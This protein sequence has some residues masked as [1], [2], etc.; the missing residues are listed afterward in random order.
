MKFCLYPIFEKTTGQ[1]FKL[2]DIQNNV[3]AFVWIFFWFCAELSFYKY[4][5][6][7]IRKLTIKM[8]WSPTKN[9]YVPRNRMEGP[10]K[11]K[12]LNRISRRKK[13][14]N[15]NVKILGSYTIHNTPYKHITKTVNHNQSKTKTTDSVYH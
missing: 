15:T 3:Y 9:P 1:I 12:L 11:S 14:F 10:N 6:I 7:P 13:K 4:I 8:L 5:S 2:I